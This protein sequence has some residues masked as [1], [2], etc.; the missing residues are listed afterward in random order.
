MANVF[1]IKVQD[2]ALSKYSWRQ[3]HPYKSAALG[4]FNQFWPIMAICWL[5]KCRTQGCHPTVAL[6][7]G[8]LCLK[9]FG[10]VLGFTVLVTISNSFQWYSIIEGPC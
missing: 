6:A 8:W 7:K 5:W 3:S 1:W 10:L 4:Q 9:G 2:S